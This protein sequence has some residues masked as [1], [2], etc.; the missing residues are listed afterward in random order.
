MQV[1]SI[2]PAAESETRATGGSCC[3]YGALEP[4]DRLRSGCSSRSTRPRPGQRSHGIELDDETRA[5]V[6]VDRDLKVL[7]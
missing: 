2:E 5:L 7:P 3:H 1:N 6:R 4:G